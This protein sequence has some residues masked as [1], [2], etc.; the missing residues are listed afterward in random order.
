MT[1]RIKIC[2]ITNREDALLAV[3]CGAD[4]LGFVFSESPR[5]IEPEQAD[6]IIQELPP[7]VLTVGVFVNAPRDQVFEVLDSCALDVIQLHGD[8]TPTRCLELKEYNK[9]VVKAIRVKDAGSFKGLES[10]HVDGFLLDAHVAGMRC[11]TGKSFEW[12]LLKKVKIKKP[13]ILSGGL[14]ADN[15]I[16]AIKVVRPYGV[17]ASSRLEKSPGKKDPAKVRAF[18][19]AVKKADSELR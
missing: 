2:G 18:I 6:A 19:E 10:Y 14:H 5:Q 17:D 4:A 3:K 7:F 16:E 12:D 9:R 13:I 1:T 8:E 11:G 15:V